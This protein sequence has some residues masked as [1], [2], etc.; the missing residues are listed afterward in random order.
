[1][2]VNQLFYSDKDGLDMAVKHPDTL[3]FKSKAEADARDKMLELA[4]NIR[5]FLMARVEGLSEELADECSVAIAQNK[6]LFQKALKKPDV[7]VEAVADKDES[8]RPD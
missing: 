5:V 1:M 4:E 6:A 3:L 2:A 7:L 8:D